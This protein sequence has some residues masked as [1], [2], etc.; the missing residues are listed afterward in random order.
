[1]HQH[2]SR[3][4]GRDRGAV[5]IVVFDEVTGK[6]GVVMEPSKPTPHFWKLPAGGIEEY[7]VDPK[8]PTD[9]HIAA[10]RAAE[11]EAK[12]KLSLP[13]VSVMR[14]GVIPKRSHTLYLYAGLADFSR[15]GPRGEEGE[16]TNAFTVDEIAALPTFMETHRQHLALAIEKIRF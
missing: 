4:H 10:D 9:N 11:R 5:I 12:E 15:M 1:M 2:V 14:L 16:I 8:N 3:P 13:E 6:V 7:D